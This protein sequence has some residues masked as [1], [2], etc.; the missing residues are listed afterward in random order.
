MNAAEQVAT[1]PIA[2]V[3][4]GRRLA[5]V[6]P[7]APTGA[8]GPRALMAAGVLL[9][10][11]AALGLVGMTSFPNADPAGAR[12]PAPAG[13][14]S[15]VEIGGPADVSVQSATYEPGQRSDWHVHTGMHAVMVLSGTLTIYDGNCRATRYGPGDS[16]V[17]GQ[18]LHLAVNEDAVPAQLAVTYL[19][20]KGV[21]HTQFHAVSPAP[22]CTPG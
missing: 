15:A 12:P 8:A 1:Y 2:A 4:T 5:M 16:Y 6:R 19:F 9:V 14:S 10:A 21:S 22:A 11:S 7:P 3:P 20:P 13:V 17:G 18:D